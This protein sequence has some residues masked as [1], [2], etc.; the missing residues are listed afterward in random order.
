MSDVP[1]A[2]VIRPGVGGPGTGGTSG[3]D[4]ECRPA[5]PVVQDPD[6]P[7]A[8]QRIHPSRCGAQEPAAFPYRERVEIGGVERVRLVEVG[9]SAVEPGVEPVDYA[10]G[11]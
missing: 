5:L 8:E 2:I 11:V 9:A 3:S 10:G 6:I 4:G 7:S 1:V